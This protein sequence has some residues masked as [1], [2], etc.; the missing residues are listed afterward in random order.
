MIPNGTLILNLVLLLWLQCLRPSL[1]KMST[2]VV[3]VDGER[4]RRSCTQ[5]P[6]LKVS[7]RTLRVHVLKDAYRD[8]YSVEKGSVTSSIEWDTSPPSC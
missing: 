4:Y 2:S 8:T 5:D 6:D 1:P 3:G 7:S